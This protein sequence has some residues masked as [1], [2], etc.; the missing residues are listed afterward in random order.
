MSRVLRSGASPPSRRGME[1]VGLAR[2]P[3]I[4]DKTM[5]SEQAEGELRVNARAV[6]VP[7]EV[8]DCPHGGGPPGRWCRK[9]LP[10]LGVM[11]IQRHQLDRHS[12]CTWEPVPGSWFCAPPRLSVSRRGGF[13]RNVGARTS[14]LTIGASR[15]DVGTD[16]Q[17][18]SSITNESTISNHGSTNRPD[19]FLIPYPHAS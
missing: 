14:R 9:P 5:T 16:Q 11:F 12:A 7:I 10:G 1:T 18:Q 17:S 3:E 8:L 4:E 13:L 15:F 19:R 6:G 2:R